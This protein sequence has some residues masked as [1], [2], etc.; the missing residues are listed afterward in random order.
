MA[1]RPDLSLLKHYSWA[2]SSCIASPLSLIKIRKMNILL[3]RLLQNGSDSTQAF[4]LYMLKIL[5][6]PIL[7]YISL[8]WVL[9]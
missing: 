8:F 4:F 7:D 3:M 6:H 1:G 2:L 5:V 9:R